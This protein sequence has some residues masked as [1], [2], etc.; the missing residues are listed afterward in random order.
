MRTFLPHCSDRSVVTPRNCPN[1]VCNA[2]IG[3][4]FNLGRQR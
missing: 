3:Q 4:A 1:P 2:G